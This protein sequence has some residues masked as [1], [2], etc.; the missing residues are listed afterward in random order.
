M[1]SSNFS[2][3]SMGIRLRSIS[4]N[5]SRVPSL[6]NIEGPCQLQIFTESDLFVQCLPKYLLKDMLIK[7]K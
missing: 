1:G 5:N 7:S 4:V 2:D 6:H 3:R